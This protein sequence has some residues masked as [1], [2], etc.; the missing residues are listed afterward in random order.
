VEVEGS[1]REINRMAPI[2]RTQHSRIAVDEIIG[3]RSFSLDKVLELDGEF[4]RDEQDHQHDSSVSSVGIECEGDCDHERLNTWVA[5][6]LKEKGVDIF[7]MKGVLSIKGSNNRFV[8][9]GIHMIF[10]G[11]PQGEW[12]EGEKRLNRIVFIGRNLDRGEL[13]TGFKSTL[14]GTP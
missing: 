11:Q 7:R 5:T 8:F 4:L 10:G 1:I 2:H 3:I 6:L 9:Q 12:A 14:E 13:V